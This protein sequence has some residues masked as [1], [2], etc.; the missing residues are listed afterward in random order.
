MPFD[1]SRHLDSRC[2]FLHVMAQDQIAKFFNYTR[3]EKMLSARQGKV[4]AR[5][6]KRNKRAEE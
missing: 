6:V 2:L 4:N 1:V 5:Y 3:P